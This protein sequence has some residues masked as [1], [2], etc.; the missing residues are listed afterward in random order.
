MGIELKQKISDQVEAY[1]KQ[2]H[3][4]QAFIPGKTKINYAGRVYDAKELKNL[5]DSSL[6]FWLT[7]GRYSNELE[8]EFRKYFNAQRVFLVNSGSSANLL[9]VA[10]LLS[11]SLKGRLKP[12]DEIITPAVTFPTSLGPIVQL[13]LIPVFVDCEIGTYNINARLIEK[14]VSKKTKA[15][16]IP[17]TLGNPCDMDIIVSIAKKHKLF[18]LEDTCD[19][20]G[21][22]FN[23]KLVGTFGDLASLSFYPAHHITMGEGGGVVVN[24]P[25][26]MKIVLSLRDWGR[27]CWCKP[28][29]SNTCRRRFSWEKGDLPYGY[30]HKYIYSNIG[31]NLKITDM[32]AAVGMAQFEKLN[33]FIKV[34]NANFNYYYE[35]LKPLEDF[36]IL[37]TIH[38]KA[39]PSWFGFPITVKNGINRLDLIRW[40]ESF[41]I[42]TRLVFAGNIVRQPAF[43]NIKYRVYGQLQESDR[44]MNDTF[45]IGVY[46]GITKPM[47]E[48][49]VKKIEDFFKH[50]N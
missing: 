21:A 18:I 26:M 29:E 36:I 30:D 17:H 42:E 8:E 35:R 40:L 50:K 6:D 5:V 41:G 1:Y 9:L 14:A 49:V 34:R 12:G 7:A 4:K 13:G 27:D 10:T 3:K 43:K 47:R 37:P 20:L 48:F 23:G 28:G 24:N 11:Q 22:R 19:A 38:P 45:F 31:Y 32:Q 16:F 2:W 15:I 44:V 39:K 25:S 46:P 33:S